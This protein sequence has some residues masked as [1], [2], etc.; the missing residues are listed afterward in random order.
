MSKQRGEKESPWKVNKC[1]LADFTVGAEGSNIITVAIQLKD[2]RGNAVA[3]RVSLPFF[4]SD[5]ANGDSI[6]ATGVTS[7]AAGTDGVFI[8]DG[9]SAKSG[10]LVT[11][12]DGQADLA[13]EFTGGAKT[14]YLVLI[15]PDGSLVPS[16]AIVFA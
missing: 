14:L 7:L 3:E 2:C 16:D 9:V 12:A 8:N 15:M 1:K 11:E 13:I 4:L 5:D 10:R 6:V